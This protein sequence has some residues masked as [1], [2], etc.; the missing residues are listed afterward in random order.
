VG[1]PICPFPRRADFLLSQNATIMSYSTTIRTFFFTLAAVGLL[2]LTACDQTID[3][4][5]EQSLPIDQVFQDVSGAQSA[6]TGAYSG[7]QSNGVYGGFQVMAADFT[8]DVA[9]FDGSFTTWQQAA[10]FNISSTHGPTENIWDDHYDV[11]NRVN[12]IIEN[13]PN[14]EGADQ[15]QI[16]DL[17]GQAKFIRAL[18][19]F[20]LVRW[21]GQPYEPGA[22]NDQ[23]GVILQTDGVQS[24][25]P[26][27]NQP[28]ASVGAIYEQIRTD[29]EDATSRLDVKAERIRAGKAVANALLAKVSLYQG[30]YDEARNRADSV[31]TNPN[32]ELSEDPTVPYANESNPE[33]IFST[34]FSSIDNSGTNDFM[35]SFYL[36]SDFGGRGDITVNSQFLSDADSGDVRATPA[37][38]SDLGLSPNNPGPEIK[39]DNL[40]YTYADGGGA[41]AAWTNKWTNPNFGDDMPVLR[42]AEM[43]LIRAEAEARSSSG[44][45][46]QA[47]ED[48]NAIRNRAG[49]SDVSSSLSGQALIDEIIKQRRY[50]LAFEADRRHDLQRLG[51]PIT[52]SSGTIQ[53]GDSQR[54]LPIPARE[55]EVNDALDE[56]SQNPG[57]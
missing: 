44:S 21:F 57:Y 22:S 56:G 23:P 9:N 34:S 37:S 33:I 31:I 47:R 4:S 13:A 36:P 24:T 54:I 35:S 27:F 1:P 8:A 46:S 26:D 10:A 15:G 2:V 55:I 7:L 45:A 17:V 32:F 16:D 48:V 41:L 43:Y 6:L 42:V 52:S 5:P 40:L 14:I 11:I 19:Y 3:K 39:G 50:E 12:L 30:R 53:P 28:R 51:R 49:L 25:N 18:S 38:G 29:L 20:N